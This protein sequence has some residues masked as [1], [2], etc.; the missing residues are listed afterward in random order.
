MDWRDACDIVRKNIVK[1][2]ISDP[3]NPTSFFFGTGWISYVEGQ[4]IKIVTAYHVIEKFYQQKMPRLDL[5][6][7]KTKSILSLSL[8]QTNFFVDLKRDLAVIEI[9]TTEQ[10][11]ILPY[12]TQNTWRAGKEAGWLGYPEIYPTELAFFHGYISINDKIYNRY[13]ID[14][15]SI[16]GLSG[17]PVF[18]YDDNQNIE[19]I[20]I[21]THYLANIN[22]VGLSLPGLIIT[23]HWL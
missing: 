5:F 3:A 13:F 11:K 19:V 16:Q 9:N 7:E 1:L 22:H 8:S 21:I 23:T 6:F 14:G 17:G 4:K 2:S 20:G 15:V 18:V 10:F 12:A